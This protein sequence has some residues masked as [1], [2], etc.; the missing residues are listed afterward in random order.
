[1][2]SSDCSFG[3][4]RWS[5]LALGPNGLIETC[6]SEVRDSDIVVVIVG[7]RYGS[8]VPGGDISYSEAEYQEAYRLKKPCL[9]YILDGSAK[10]GGPAEESHEKLRSLNGWKAIL[11]ERH[12]PAH[13]Q[14]G[15]KL[16]VQVAVDLGREL[17]RI[18]AG[19]RGLKLSQK[20]VAPTVELTIR[21]SR[22]FGY[23]ARQ[24]LHGSCS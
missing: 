2:R 21:A 12:T 20:A 10:L 22:R 14:D 16:A 7:N 15:S 9:V 11:S 4:I 1:M 19:P 18:E 6:L 24:L 5:F 23:E 3:I 13:L 17:N 8:L